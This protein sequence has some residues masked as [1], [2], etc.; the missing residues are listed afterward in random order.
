VSAA[1]NGHGQKGSQN[2]IDR[3]YNLIAFVAW[4]KR[5]ISELTDRTR[6][7]IFIVIMHAWAR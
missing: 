3:F 5:I 1:A 7:F 6:L 4:W 2:E